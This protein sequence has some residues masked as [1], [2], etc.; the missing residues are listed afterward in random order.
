MSTTLPDIKLL[1]K[2]VDPVIK[3]YVIALESENLKLQKKIAK[4]QVDKVSSKNRITA[5]EKE[6]E[7]QGSAAIKR[8]MDKVDIGGLKQPEKSE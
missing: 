1:L 6:I 2:S 4:F 8:L 3:N 5:L 7:K